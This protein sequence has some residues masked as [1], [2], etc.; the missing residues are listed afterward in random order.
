[1][2]TGVTG[3][4]GVRAV[5]PAEEA[6]NQDQDSAT[7]LLLPMVEQPVLEAQWKLR[8]ATLRD[9]Q[10]VRSLKD[11]CFHSVWLKWLFKKLFSTKRIFSKLNSCRWF[12]K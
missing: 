5:S 8:H 2:E 1:M 4:H 6:P 3:V 7:I 12:P 9:A 10:L 11:K